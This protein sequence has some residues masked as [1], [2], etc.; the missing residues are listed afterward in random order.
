MEETLISHTES[1]CLEFGETLLSSEAIS[2]S[3]GCRGL[4]NGQR[5]KTYSL[6]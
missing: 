3:A 4:D 5:R 2:G 6:C 1:F